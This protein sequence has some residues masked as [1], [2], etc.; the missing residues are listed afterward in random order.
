M[1]L[2]KQRPTIVVVAALILSQSAGLGLIQMPGG[3]QCANAFNFGKKKNA[4][5]QDATDG[6]NTKDAKGNSDAD[7]GDKGKADKGKSDKGKADKESEGDEP[8]EKVKHQSKAEI[9]EEEELQAEYDVLQKQLKDTL[10]ATKTPF[11]SNDAQADKA[12]DGPLG[13]ISISGNSGASTGQ[14]GHMSLGA[15]LLQNKLYMPGH[16]MI[17]RP[18]EFTVKGPPGYWAALAMADKDKGAKPIYGHA[19]RLGPDRKVVALGKIPASGVLA[20][21][22]FA[23]IEGD[24]V[25]SSLYF[26]AAIWPENRPE[27][28]EL[29]LPVSSETQT[30]S[31]A[32]GVSLTGQG[33][34]K[35]GIKFVPDNR[36]PYSHING[37]GIGS[38]S[39]L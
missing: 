2:L 10:K 25:G 18:A 9:K 34:R 31:T 17:G 11:G 15:R 29:A 21:K 32:N 12:D 28:L 23:P 4:D 26:E 37:P 6:A 20:L 36:S 1:S 8:K 13:T 16:M 30:V 14:T 3:G 5:T 7:D 39:P 19:L 27:R 35:H 22:I 33:E 24:L 38:G